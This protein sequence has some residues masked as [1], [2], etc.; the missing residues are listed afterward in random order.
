M[1]ILFLAN[2]MDCKDALGPIQVSVEM[3]LHG[4][5]L[6]SWHICAT[7]AVTGEGVEEGVVWLTDQIKHRL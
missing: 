2:K 3:C 7:N 1:P 4:V 6:H 5:K